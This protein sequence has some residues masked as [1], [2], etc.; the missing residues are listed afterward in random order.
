MTLALENRAAALVFV[1]NHPSGDPNPST[2]D[3]NLTRDLVWSSQ[4][5]MIQVLD[6]V[7]IGNNNYYSF[8]DKGL[9]SRF[10]REYEERLNSSIS[11]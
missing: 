1:H 2:E 5:L 9:I 11:T 7:I 6:H 3:L 8:A 4:L 10:I